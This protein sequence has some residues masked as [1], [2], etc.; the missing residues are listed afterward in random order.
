MNNELHEDLY[1]IYEKPLQLHEKLVRVFNGDALSFPTVRKWVRW[2]SSLTSHRVAFTQFY[3]ILWTIE[4]F[5][6]SGSQMHSQ[7]NK[8]RRVSF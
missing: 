8:K 1:P 5:Q 7:K 3:T 6:H 2:A 4:R